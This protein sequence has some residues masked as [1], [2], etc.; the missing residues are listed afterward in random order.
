ML[1]SEKA[2]YPERE[3][4]AQR[5]DPTGRWIRYLARQQRVPDIGENSGFTMGFPLAVEK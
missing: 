5:T 2:D 1:S 3:N 4:T